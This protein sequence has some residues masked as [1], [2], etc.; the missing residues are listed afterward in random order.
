MAASSSLS[1]SISGIRGRFRGSDARSV[2]GT[3]L[4]GQWSTFA[5]SNFVIGTP[6]TLPTTGFAKQISG[7][8][9]H[10]YLNKISVSEI[11]EREFWTLA[12][13]VKAFAQHEGFPAHT[14]SVLVRE[15]SR[16]GTEGMAEPLAEA[17]EAS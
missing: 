14:A 12:A 17:P 5:C 11:D 7:V 9:A 2:A 13:P 15:V 6:A 8:T 1:I 10:T 3:A 16:Q 4:L